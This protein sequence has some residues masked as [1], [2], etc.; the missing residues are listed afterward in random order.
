MPNEDFDVESLADYLRVRPEQIAR[1]AERGKLP[2]RRIG[3]NWRFSQAEIHHWWE[4]RIG[5]SGDEEL[6]EVE[7]AL[8]RSEKAFSLGDMLPEAAIAVPLEARTRSSVITGMI[9]LAA[10]TGLL[11]D[12]DRMDEAVRARENLHPTAL[13]NGV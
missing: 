8:Q 11:W 5:V 9:R 4:D 7:L 12:E 2:G 6:A 13:D 3:G 1:L 10:G